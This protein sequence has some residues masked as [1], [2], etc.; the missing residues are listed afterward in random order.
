MYT[1]INNCCFCQYFIC[2][3]LVPLADRFLCQSYMIELENLQV[4]TSLRL[5]PAHTLRDSCLEVIDADGILAAVCGT[6][7][8]YKPK[9]DLESATA[10]V[11]A[12]DLLPLIGRRISEDLGSAPLL[13]PVL[14]RLAIS[15]PRQLGKCTALFNCDA[16]PVDSFFW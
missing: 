10:A 15:T 13:C 5:M 1:Y 16:A 4:G 11:A 12:W 3:V 8:M 9:H 6:G 7:K 2:F 14:A